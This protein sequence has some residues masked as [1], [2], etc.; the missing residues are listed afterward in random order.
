MN[1]QGKPAEAMKYLEPARVIWTKKYGRKHQRVALIHQNISV[2]LA[3]LNRLD[4]AINMRRESMNI[5]IEL[6]GREHINVA[7]SLNYIG[8]YL[9]KLGRTEACLDHYRQAL[10]IREKIQEK[11]DPE[12]IATGYNI[13]L[14]YLQLDK[15]S[16]ALKFFMDAW[17]RHIDSRRED[18][19]TTASLHRQIGICMRM[20]GEYHGDVETA[21]QSFNYA[22]EIRRRIFGEESLE[23]ADIYSDLGE[24]RLRNPADR[25]QDIQRALDIRLKL[26]GEKYLLGTDY[27]HKGVIL[28]QMNRRSEGM[29]NLRQALAIFTTLPNSNIIIEARKQCIREL[30]S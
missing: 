24:T 23:V 13:G 30:N 11:N 14:G 26:G 28:K 9:N 6:Y 19:E 2:S 12:I 4:D 10:E 16:D 17:K 3:H 5:D 20:M 18:D 1:N 7:R 22:L 15:P 8:K 29:E 21:M 27:Y 25:L